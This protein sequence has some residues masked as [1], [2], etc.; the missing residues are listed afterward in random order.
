M[1]S[2]RYEFPKYKLTQQ[3]REPGGVAVAEAVEAAGANL[4]QLRPE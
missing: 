4:E 3:V 2:V 1:S